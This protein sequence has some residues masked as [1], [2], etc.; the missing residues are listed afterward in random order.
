MGPLS[1]SE[2]A[3][4]SF[5]FYSAVLGLKMLFMSYLTGKQRFKK[6]V[7]ANVEDAKARKG[8]VKYD[9]PDVERVRRAHLNDIEN[10]PVFWVLGALY[11]T[12]GPSTFI[13][14]T[15]FRVVAACRILYTIVY[16]V[17]PIPPPARGI[18]FGIP[19]LASVY[20]GA[21]VVLYY[22]LDL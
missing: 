5:I 7:Y 21:N 13:A 3:V 20:M 22:L 14:T 16:A 4:R 15:L 18:A 6:N 19:L 2:P 17:K 9:D 8:T 12:T 1:L 10:I 11:L